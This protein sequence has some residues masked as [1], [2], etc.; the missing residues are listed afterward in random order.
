MFIRFV[1]A[2]CSTS[3][4]A[5][6]VDLRNIRTPGAKRVAEKDGT[7]F[8]CQLAS[9]AKSSVEFIKRA[10]FVRTTFRRCLDCSLGEIAELGMHFVNV[11]Q[12]IVK[13]SEAQ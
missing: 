10:S 13:V 6:C 5:E 4:I 9:C 11:A 7:L 8:G 12:T 3:N 2:R 1:G